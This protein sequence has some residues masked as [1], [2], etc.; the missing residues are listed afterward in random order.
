MLPRLPLYGRRTPAV[1][2]VDAE[3]Q[4]CEAC[5]KRFAYDTMGLATK[6]GFECTIVVVWHH[7]QQLRQRWCC[8]CEVRGGREGIVGTGARCNYPRPPLTFTSRVN[9]MTIT[10][11]YLQRHERRV[12]HP[13]D[14][15]KQPGSWCQATLVTA[16]SYLGHGA[17]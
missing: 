17:K 5:G 2:Y 13:R 10:L 16:A 7:W 8:S 6:C 12:I 9:T 15:A 1:T 11:E 4:H 14:G 3:M